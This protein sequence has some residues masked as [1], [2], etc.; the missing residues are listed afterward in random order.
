MRKIISVFSSQQRNK[1]KRNIRKFKAKVEFWVRPVSIEKMEK[2]LRVDLGIV[3]GDKIFVTSAFGS[4]NA[5]FSPKELL[6]LLMSIVGDKGL[7]VMPFYP[8]GS[9]GEWAAGGDV[10]DLEQTK[11]SMGILTNIFSEMPDVYKSNHPTKAVCAWGSNAEQIVKGHALCVSPFA[12]DSPYGKLMKL[13]SKSLGLA[14]GKCPMGHCCEDLLNPSLSHYY[15]PVML[16]VREKGVITQYPI[17]IHNLKKLK[18]APV[19]YIKH[20]ADYRKMKIGYSFSYIMEN[21]KIMEYYRSEFLAG[22]TSL[23]L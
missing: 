3:S 1:I 21:D 15:N 12:E 13:H 20:S 22:R 23:I 2:V 18:I 17:R 19:D 9:S 11:S 6:K 7:I 5:T 10:F 16:S 4:L 8:R 14:T